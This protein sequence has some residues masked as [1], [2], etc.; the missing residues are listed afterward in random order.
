MSITSMKGEITC[1]VHT[2]GKELPIEMILDGL[3][4]RVDLPGDHAY[5][6]I[7]G[8][9]ANLQVV[10]SIQNYDGKTYTSE[11]RILKGSEVHILDMPA[12]K[13]GEGVYETGSVKIAFQELTP[14]EGIPSSEWARGDWGQVSFRYRTG[15]KE[16]NDS[17]QA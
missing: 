14:Q 16:P 2:D 11:P 15:Q 17:S 13:T 1:S 12:P 10:L 9:R 5:L 4:Q 7:Q 6:F 3:D 8:T